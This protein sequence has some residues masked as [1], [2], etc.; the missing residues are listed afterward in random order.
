[1]KTIKIAI[2]W[3]LSILVIAGS[4]SL[5]R[6]A[7]AQEYDEEGVG[8]EATGPQ[9]NDPSATP[10]NFN[11]ALTPYGQ[12]I[13][14]PDYGR[15]WRPYESSVGSDFAP[16]QTGG[17]WVYSTY[18]WTWT[19]DWNWGWA[20]FHYGRWFYDPANGWVW[21]PDTVWGPGWVD[22]RFGGGYIGWAPM[23]PAWFN[24][25]WYHPRWCF[26]EGRM[27]FAGIP[28]PDPSTYSK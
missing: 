3:A 18:G 17:H 25:G 28:D 7:H 15:V 27:A 9:G 11:E 6:G 2:T 22:W 23:G 13:E 19:S 21:L 16:Y 10:E 1:M 4:V 20:P 26:Y 12:W 5:S 8:A 14:S 24:D